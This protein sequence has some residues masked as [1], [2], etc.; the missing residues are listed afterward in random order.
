VPRPAGFDG[1]PPAAGGHWRLIDS[2]PG[3][4]PWNLALDDAIFGAVRD[5]A[6]PPTLR[7]YR[8][9][10]PTLSLGYAQQRRRD[11]D[12]DACAALGIA[13]LRRATGGRAVLHDREVTYSVSAPAGLPLFGSG[14]DPAYRAIAAGL[15]AGLRLLGV[16]AE[17]APAPAGR[18]GRH[19][20]C[21]AARSRHE[22]GVGG[23]KLVGSAQRRERGAFLQHGS[24]LLDGHDER[25]AQLL[26]P[27][28]GAGGGA[29]MIGLAE[30]LGAAPPAEQVAAAVAAG[31][32]A[33]WKVALRP[34]A[35]SGDELREARRLERERYRS[36]AWN[37]GR[38]GRA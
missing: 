4:G 10:A 35:P 30:L 33:A 38:D 22:L 21:F 2:G 15:A 3:S 6:S 34:G 26:R 7:L 23:R 29:R 32:A 12:D 24:V 13:V 14:L 9:D 25:L 5:G 1:G 31:C 36:P 28:G 11:V 37:D 20:G 17:P 8:W 16:V 27:A 19:P 18:A